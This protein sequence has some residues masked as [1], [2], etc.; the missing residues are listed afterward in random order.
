M[1]KHPINTKLNG[2]IQGFK[3][4]IQTIWNNLHKWVCHQCFLCCDSMS[5]RLPRQNVDSELA[6][7]PGN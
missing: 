1:G 7:T 4:V 3:N 5:G 2:S 6:T